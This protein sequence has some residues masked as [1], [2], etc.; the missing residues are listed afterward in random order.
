MSISI[1]ISETAGFVANILSN[2]AFLPQIIKSYRTKRVD[3]ISITMFLTLFTTQVC[4]I[5]YAVPIH[6][7]NLWTSSLIEIAL[8]LP[9]FFMWMKYRNNRRLA[10][11]DG[12]VITLPTK[13]KL[14]PQFLKKRNPIAMIDS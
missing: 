12:K 9:I 5:L 11:D 13:Q 14:T 2:L 3:D 10:L 1:S 6:A 4:W 7:S 8:L